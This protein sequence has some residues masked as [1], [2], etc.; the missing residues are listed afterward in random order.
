MKRP[1]APILRD[2]FERFAFACRENA[3]DRGYFTYAEPQFEQLRDE[4]A[5]A[6][7]A[8]ERA[9]AGWDARSQGHI[10]RIRAGNNLLGF[11][12][13]RG[14]F[15]K[16]QAGQFDATQAATDFEQEVAREH[17][18]LIQRFVL[19]GLELGSPELLFRRGRFVKLTDSTF[20]SL[21]GT[22]PT[23]YDRRLGL[24]VLELRWRGPNPP[25]GTGALEE[26]ESAQNRVQR[27][28]EPWIAFI[29][30]W[31]RG[32]I[33]VAGVFEW[34][35][36]GLL[37]SAHRYIEIGE[38]VWQDNYEH[39]DER[40]VDEWAS[41]SPRWTITVHDETRFV[42]F[43]ER[44]DDG[45]QRTGTEA[46]RAD[47][48]TRY[49]RRV[50]E[51]YWIHHL[52]GEGSSQDP[53]EDIVVDAMTALEAIL[54]ANEKNDK[55]GLMAARAAAILEEA[56]DERRRVR[57]RI[58]R[59]YRLRSALLHGDLRPSTAEL[60]EAALD[61]EEFARRCLAAFLLTGGDRQAVL[62]AS[63]DAA[64]AEALRRRIAP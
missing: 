54:L 14:A 56:G 31:D 30:L 51:N 45:L 8:Y 1:D 19:D 37:R 29:N 24:Y 18:L 26:A 46:H 32:K 10:R 47:I 4:V 6:L 3:T 16:I 15:A 35:D 60:T 58:Q 12:E 62:R 49:F 39:N 48:A 42:N 22:V 52:G 36:S 57:K 40:D 13:R 27:M 50:V 25:W 34:S 28:A 63:T 59:L 20:T 5:F 17:C 11:L 23:S 33:R 61:A 43:L 2:A 53:N 41:E 7:P 9:A 44:L 55:G 64:T 21:T 38:P